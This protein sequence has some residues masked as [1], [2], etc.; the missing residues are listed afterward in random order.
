MSSPSSTFVAPPV[1]SEPR[2]ALMILFSREDRKF[3]F[4]FIII[5]SFAL[6]LLDQTE[7]T[8]LIIKY[9]LA[10]REEALS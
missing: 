2:S 4:M 5:G 1:L 6:F 10:W 7:L 9:C 8:G 3:F